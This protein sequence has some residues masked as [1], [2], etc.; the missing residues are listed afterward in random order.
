[1]F[2]IQTYI[3]LFKGEVAY[4][5]REI[6]LQTGCVN[7]FWMVT[8]VSLLVG[9]AEKL[10]PWRKEQSFVRKQF[11]LDV[12]YMYFNFFLFK[13]FFLGFVGLFFTEG[14]KTLVG[15]PLSSLALWD[16][17]TLPLWL[18]LIIFFVVLDF[19]QWVTHV[20]LHRFE[21]L[22]QFHAVH[23]SVEEMS[24]P[25][26]LRY[27]WM[28]N[29]V[30][31]PVKY[32]TVALLFG[33]EPQAVFLT[34]YFATI[35]G[36]LNHANIRLTYGPLKY[37]FN[38]SRMHIWHHSKKLPKERRYGVNFGISLS[39]WDYLLRTDYIPEDGKD[40]PLGFPGVE[41]FPQRF[42]DQQLYPFKL[43]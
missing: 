1:M 21:F 41:R 8:L 39:I 20:A 35:I 17:T 3:T 25:A 26:H 37:I 42:I 22:W 13:L 11:W 9:I 10:F 33:V 31:T 29:V 15:K 38:N 5:W 12:F 7:Y 40:I 14:W 19:V 18:Q 6:T 27:H 28:E 23:H 43:Q 4:L 24:F 2:D 16:L 32:L 34:Y 36:H 30:Y